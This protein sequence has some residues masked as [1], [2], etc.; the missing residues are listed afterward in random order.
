MTPTLHDLALHY[1]AQHLALPPDR[2][3]SGHWVT[4]NTADLEAFAAKIDAAAVAR[5]VARLRERAGKMPLP[6]YRTV[7]AEMCALADELERGS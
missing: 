3:D 1:I 2:V 6:Q 5:C 4:A 7:A